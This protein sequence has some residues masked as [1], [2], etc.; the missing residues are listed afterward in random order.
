MFS[1]IRKVREIMKFQVG[2]VVLNP[3]RRGV[4]CVVSAIT[5]KYFIL[6]PFT[7]SGWPSRNTRNWQY[8]QS[9]TIDTLKPLNK[10]GGYKR[11]LQCPDC[12][13]LGMTLFQ[14]PLRK[15]SAYSDEYQCQTCKHEFTIS[16]K[17]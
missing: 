16:E 5:P 2:D 1:Q 12:K 9:T 13:E 3:K 8:H 7:K 15:L 6:Q 11:L 17:G 4:C 14:S 10:A